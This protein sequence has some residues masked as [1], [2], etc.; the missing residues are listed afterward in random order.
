[1]TSLGAFS[2]SYARTVFGGVPGW[3]APVLFY[4]SALVAMI[5]L[6]WG[7]WLK[8]SLWQSGGA[9]P[10]AIRGPLD[11]GNGWTL[12]WRA[13]VWFFSAECMFALRVWRRGFYRW[14]ML[15]M[16][17]W[18]F[19]ILFAGSLVL[20]VSHDF[21][22]NFLYGTVYYDYKL[23]LNWAGVAFLV[24]LLG[25]ALRR[26]VLA[27]PKECLYNAEDAVMLLLFFFIGLTGFMLQGA[28]MAALGP[29][30]PELYWPTLGGLVGRWFLA[31]GPA[32][33]AWHT[34]LWFIHVYLALFM[35]AYVPFSK[36]FHMYAAPL[37]SGAA[38]RRRYIHTG[39]N[40]ASATRSVAGSDQAVKG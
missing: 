17:M 1:M 7:I 26:Y 22:G 30:V 8:V 15:I 24:G 34:A 14:I 19:L 35:I 3:E 13:V 36:M 10:A 11:E 12:A 23:I 16:V 29:A 40:A 33:P 2:Q 5:I 4:L 18:G 9:D 27:K 31:L 38:L 6:V 20:M 28:R 25:M 37:A 21:G 39:G 32:A